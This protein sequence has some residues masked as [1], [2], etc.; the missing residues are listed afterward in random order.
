[1]QII[2]FTQKTSNKIEQ[3]KALAS[4]YCLLHSI[5]LSDTDLTVLAYFI[6]Y[7]ITQSTKDLIIKSEIL[8]NGDSLKNT[9]S[10]LKSKG[11]IKKSLLKKEYLINDNLNIVGENVVVV[12]IKI[13]NR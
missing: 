4:V 3:A 11:L 7:K 13:D 6:V 12:L 8:K 2:K 10:K 5:N 1:M 9:I